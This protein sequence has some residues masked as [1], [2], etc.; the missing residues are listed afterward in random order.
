MDPVFAAVQ[1]SALRSNPK[2]KPGFTCEKTSNLA[3]HE[4]CLLTGAGATASMSEV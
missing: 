3:E 1:R 2:E 4:H